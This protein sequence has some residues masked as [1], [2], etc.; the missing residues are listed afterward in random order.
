MPGIDEYQYPDIA[1]NLTGLGIGARRVMKH[2]SPIGLICSALQPQR[3]LRVNRPSCVLE[4]GQ[5]QYVELMCRKAL[6]GNTVHMPLGLQFREDH[7][8][9]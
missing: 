2:L 4:D 3:R 5:H 9:R 1:L 6:W 7:P 8:S